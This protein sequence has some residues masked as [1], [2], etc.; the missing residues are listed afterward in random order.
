VY[1]RDDPVSQEESP[2]IFLFEVVL[3]AQGTFL[4]HILVR[5]TLI[6]LSPHDVSFD[7]IALNPG[8]VTSSPQHAGGQRFACPK[9]ILSFFPSLDGPDGISE[10]DTIRSIR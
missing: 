1:L 3:P 2:F 10:M 4:G 9:R 8:L 5:R 7:D 6:F